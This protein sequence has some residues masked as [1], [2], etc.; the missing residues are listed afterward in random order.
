MLNFSFKKFKHY[1]LHSIKYCKQPGEQKLWWVNNYE[2]MAKNT[3]FSLAYQG[4][5]EVWLVFQESPRYTVSIQKRSVWCTDV[6][7]N[8][9]SYLFRLSCTR[10]G[11]W[12]IGYVTPGKNILQTIPQNKSL[13]QALVEGYKEK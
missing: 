4:C 12:A 2:N 10:L 3:E 8:F 5:V 6:K 7:I 11:Q 9:C 13:F 1:I